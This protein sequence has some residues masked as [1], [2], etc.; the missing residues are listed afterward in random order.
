VDERDQSQK[1]R[2]QNELSRN[3]RM[4]P[5]GSFW[6]PQS[7]DLL[8]AISERPLMNPGAAI[9]AEGIAEITRHGSNGF[10]LG[11]DS[12]RELVLAPPSRYT[13]N[14]GAAPSVPPRAASFSRD[15]RSAG[16]PKIWLASTRIQ[17]L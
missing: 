14:P 10:L 3:F 16:W 15:L 9:S 17:W 1:D 12:Q 5:A 6:E 13:M 2:W 7:R 8:P 4:P 11:L